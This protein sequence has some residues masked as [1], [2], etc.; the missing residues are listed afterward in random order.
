MPRD[1]QRFTDNVVHL[2][3]NLRLS[4]QLPQG[5]YLLV[6]DAPQVTVEW[7]AKGRNAFNFATHRPRQLLRYLRT[8][9]VITDNWQW[10]ADGKFACFAGSLKVQIWHGIPLKKIELSNLDGPRAPTGVSGAIKKLLYWLKGR[11]P[12]YDL[13]VTTSPFFLEH[14]FKPSF[15]ARRFIVTGYPRNDYLLNSESDKVEVDADLSLLSRLDLGR[16]KGEKVVFYAPTFRDHGGTPFE[17]GALNFAHL[18]A[19]A[20]GNALIVVVKLHPYLRVSERP[21]KSSRVVL[22]GAFLDAAPLL[23]RTDL[24]VTDYSSIFLDFL[25]LDRPIVFFPYDLETYFSRDRQFLFPYEE[26]T[27]GAKVETEAALFEKI[28]QELSKPSAEEELARR[29]LRDQSFQF[30]DAN[31]SERLWAEVKALRA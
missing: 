22:Y 12:L 19:F 17:D 4:G 28:I 7:T 13:M 15:R 9:V 6:S 14:A 27:P 26:F 5:A 16:K 29:K 25:L 1:G 30:V 31:A 10:A 11:Y 2:F 21:S 3:E 24:L 18:E 8:S 20:E 23:R